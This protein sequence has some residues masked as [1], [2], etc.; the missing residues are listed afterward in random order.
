VAELKAVFLD[1]D[2]TLV[3]TEPYWIE[4]ES[5][6]PRRFGAAWTVED[7]LAS[8]GLPM[9]VTARKMQ[10]AGVPLGIDEI[11]DDLC[12]Q[13]I[14]MMDDRGIPWLPG[15]S[16][17]FED[18]AAAGIP[19]AIVSNA[20]R[21][22]VEKTTAALPEGVVR[23]V[24]TGDEMLRAKPDPWP[25]AHAAEMLGVDPA[26][27]LAIEDSLAGTLSAEAAGMR[28]LVVPGVSPVPDAPG[29]SRTG[30]LTSVTVATLRAIAA[31]EVLAL[32][33]T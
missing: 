16:G 5:L 21:A 10:E 29:R 6:L 13:V 7:S 31:G 17:L 11:I 32:P 27:Q 30:S 15:V 1:H 18:L 4:A 8:V 14:A 3:D 24:L 28:V 20:W 12:Q 9:P 22:V 25:Y 2:G 33:V 19:C 26:G 23:F